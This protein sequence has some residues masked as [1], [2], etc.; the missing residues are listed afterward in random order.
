M[1]ALITALVAVIA[2]A[3]PARAD[4]TDDAFLNAMH[5]HGINGVN[6]DSDLISYGHKVCNALATGMSMNALIDNGDLHEH[7]GIGDSDVS[8]MVKTAAASYCPEYIP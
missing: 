1:K 8:F 5:R 6:G 7:N 3:V 2:L 4:G